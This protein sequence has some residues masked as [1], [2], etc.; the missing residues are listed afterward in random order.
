MSEVK[1]Q[2]RDYTPEVDALL[3][4]ATSLAEVRTPLMPVPEPGELVTELL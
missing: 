3:P 2:E 4:E 1:K